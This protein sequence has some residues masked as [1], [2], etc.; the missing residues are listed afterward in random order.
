ML[1]RLVI[2]VGNILDGVQ[3]GNKFSLAILTNEHIKVI[4]IAIIAQRGVVDDICHDFRLHS[5]FCIIGIKIPI[6][7]IIPNKICEV[8]HIGTHIIE[9][10]HFQSILVQHSIERRW[11]SFIKKDFNIGPFILYD[12]KRT[13]LLYLIGV[14]LFFLHFLLSEVTLN[15]GKSFEVIIIQVP[16]VERSVGD[17]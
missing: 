4:E 17:S 11:I 8:A 6:L 1:S 14:F 10:F 12:V 15:F 16:Q 3:I 13:I 9:Y 2:S 5:E 7:D